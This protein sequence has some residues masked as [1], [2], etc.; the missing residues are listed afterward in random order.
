M[1]LQY[2]NCADDA[3]V[4]LYTIQG[5]GHQWPGGR[6]IVANWLVGPYSHSI[7]ATEQMWTFFRAHQLPGR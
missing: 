1:R 4:V 7:D 3:S 6:P 5:E 2:T